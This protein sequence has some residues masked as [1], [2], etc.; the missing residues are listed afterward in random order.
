MCNKKQGNL[1]FYLF[2]KSFRFKPVYINETREH[3]RVAGKFI[4]RADLLVVADGNLWE[5]NKPVRSKSKM[6]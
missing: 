1:S 6:I 2:F 3:G 5:K 4:D